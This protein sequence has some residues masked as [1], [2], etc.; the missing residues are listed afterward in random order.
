ML[1]TAAALKLANIGKPTLRKRVPL[2]GNLVEADPAL[3]NRHWVPPGTRESR[4]PNDANASTTTES[5]TRTTAY[6][7]RPSCTTIRA[8]RKEA[9]PGY[10][11]IR[12]LLAISPMMPRR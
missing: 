6:R 10:R 7:V 9:E 8:D 11:R 2:L 5:C 4:Q 1:P 12:S 3:H